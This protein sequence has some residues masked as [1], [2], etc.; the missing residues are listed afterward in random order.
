MHRFALAA[1]LAAL[2]GA[3]SPALGQAPAVRPVTDVGNGLFVF[4]LPDE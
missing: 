1:A 3:A 2:A 4:A